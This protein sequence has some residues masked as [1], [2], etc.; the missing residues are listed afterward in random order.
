MR[1]AARPGADAFSR[2]NSFFYY[3]IG[4]TNILQNWKL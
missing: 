1:V 4:N 2:D 3:V